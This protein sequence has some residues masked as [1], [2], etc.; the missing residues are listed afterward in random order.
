MAS[1]P[2]EAVDAVVHSE[3][4]LSRMLPSLYIL[5]P[6]V[7]VDIPYVYRYDD[8][9]RLHWHLK[10]GKSAVVCKGVE[11]SWQLLDVIRRFRSCP[12]HV[13]GPFCRSAC[14]YGWIGKSVM[15]E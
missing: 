14:V 12:L 10:R 3:Y 15:C 13:G 5:N 4:Q 9:Y 8:R 7:Q 2:Y 1:I 11:L 6:N